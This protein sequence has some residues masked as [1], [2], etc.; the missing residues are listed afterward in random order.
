MTDI[1]MIQAI[2]KTYG[3]DTP[4]STIE[5]LTSGLINHTWKVSSG[6]RQYILQRI[7]DQVFKKPFDVA[8]NILGGSRGDDAPDRLERA[9]QHASGTMEF[10]GTLSGERGQLGE[11][12]VF[13][14]VGFVPVRSF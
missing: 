8:E 7:N 9:G 1:P 10:H 11:E 3:I 14:R 4:E 13:H 12:T 6:N 2:L 5:S